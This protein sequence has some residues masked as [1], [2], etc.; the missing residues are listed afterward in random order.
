M[1]RNR[2]NAGYTLTELLSV[3]MLVMGLVA[4]GFVVYVIIHFLM[5]F[6]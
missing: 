2:Y 3:I 6:W 1:K 5:K 4:A